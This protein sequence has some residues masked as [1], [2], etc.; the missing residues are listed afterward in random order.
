MSEP[1]SFFILG[2][3]LYAEKKI[4]S[5]IFT[6]IM[7]FC[8]VF[9]MT[10]YNLALKSGGFSYVDPKE[11]K[12]IF[13][14]LAIQCCTV[15]IIC[16]LMTFIVNVIK[17]GFRVSLLTDWINLLALSFPAAFLLQ[18]FFVGPF[19]R[20]VCSKLFSVMDSCENNVEIESLLDNE[21]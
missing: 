17:G 2:G 15:L 12:P 14:I 4:Q 20:T 5:V 21:I 18:V 1:L 8:M 3:I 10:A 11:D 13:V 6:V 19:V 9:C 7:V 16:P